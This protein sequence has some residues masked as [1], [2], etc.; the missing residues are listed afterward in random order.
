MCISGWEWV[1]ALK[2]DYL[3]KHTKICKCDSSYDCRPILSVYPVMLSLLWLLPVTEDGSLPV[4]F[5]LLNVTV[6]CELMN[7]SEAIR[8]LSRHLAFNLRNFRLFGTE[9]K[10][11]AGL[12]FEN[13]AELSWV[14]CIKLDSD[15]RRGN[16]SSLTTTQSLHWVA[17]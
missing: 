8:Q 17:A 1:K 9:L 5:L 15:E 2:N 13:R 3:L 10:P 11:A 7:V 12:G 6:C 16:E 14:G 4:S